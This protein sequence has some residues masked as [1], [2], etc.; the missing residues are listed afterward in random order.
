[1]ADN[2][3]ITPGTGATVAA[4]DVG[5]ALHQRVK[6][7]LGADGSATDMLGGAGAVAAGVQRVTLASDDPAVAA[8]GAT[9]G[10][11]V[12][13]DA[14]GTIQQY[15][16]GLVK[17][18]ITSGTVVLGAGTSLIG[19]VKT[20]FFTAASATLTRPTNNTT[21]YAANEEVSAA[22]PASLSVTVADA[23]DNPVTLERI[24]VS[25]TDTGFGGKAIRVWAYNGATTAG[26]DNAA[27]STTRANLIGTFSGTL[28]A[29]SD[30]AFGVLVPDE[31][32]RIVTL[33]A[34]GA[35]T[36]QLRL[37][38]LDAAVPSAGQTTFD[39][40]VEGFQGGTN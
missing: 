31:G 26:T 8:L 5:G 17:L 4:D 22:T 2:T 21:T 13:T 15:L 16:R 39:F 1:M 10:V 3:T 6:V 18:L 36:I 23:N 12:V 14:N 24:R 38:T 27:F 30:G 25:S 29:C 11:A 40:T 7:S 37:Q 28:R 34:S 9:S 20:P 33:P 35:K 19:K 32:S